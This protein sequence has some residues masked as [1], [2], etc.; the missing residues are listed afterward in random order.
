MNETLKWTL[1][2]TGI[3]LAAVA[4]AVLAAM[5]RNA[6]LR[7]QGR[8]SQV[9]VGG[10]LRKFASIRRFKVLSGLK[11]KNG[12]T[13]VEIDQALIGFFGIM[14]LKTCNETGS[15]YGEYR[16][17]QWAAVITD[18]HNND[19]KTTFPNPVQAAEKCNEALRKLLA[20]HNLYKIQSEAYV[21]FADPKSQLTNAKKKKGM[22]LLTLRQLKRLLEKEKY[23]ADGP[24][25]VEE[26]ARLLQENSVD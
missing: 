1:I 9:K 17:K 22:P 7:R 26:I 5:L 25:D 6:L 11:L 3:G 12:S 2:G 24:V 13:V 20:A 21:V 14:L 10:L 19:R 8:Y 16:D 4:L 18:K 15:V 23:S